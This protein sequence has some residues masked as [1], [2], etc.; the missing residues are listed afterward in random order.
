MKFLAV[1]ALVGLLSACLVAAE[2]DHVVV[3]T[4]A[5]FQE[6]LSQN[7][8]LLVEFYVRTTFIN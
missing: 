7:D 3:L 1:I 5:N 4:K 6:Q 8:I 2:E